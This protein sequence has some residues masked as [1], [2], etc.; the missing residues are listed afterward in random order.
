MKNT[1]LNEKVYE[2]SLLLEKIGKI[3]RYFQQKRNKYKFDIFAY[4]KFKKSSEE[5]DIINDYYWKF[6]DKKMTSDE[7]EYFQKT[8]IFSIKR[9][10]K[11]GKIQDKINRLEKGLK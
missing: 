1:K 7:F 10:I 6:R 9:D 5:L 8:R 3:E 2:D 11:R 4:K